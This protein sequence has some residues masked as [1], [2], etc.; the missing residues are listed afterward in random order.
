MLEKKVAKAITNCQIVLEQGI[1]W[2]SVLLIE[3]DK[4]AGYGKMGDTKIPEYAEIIDAEGKYVGPG[5]VDIHVHGGGGVDTYTDP[6]KAENH[7]LRHGE[8]TILATPPYELDRDGFLNAIRTVKEY[9]PKAKTIK[10]FNFEGP[11]T[12]P[13]YGAYSYANPWR[14]PISEEDFKPIVDE[15]GNFAIIWSIAPELEGLIP[16]LEYA[17]KVNPKTIFSVGHSEATPQE[18]RAL[19]KYRPRLTTHTMNAM[20]RK[21]VYG[22][23]RSYGPDEYILKESDVYAEVISDSMAI[24]VR[25]EMQRF[26]LRGKGIDRTILITDSTYYENDPP[27]QFKNIDDLNFDQRGG[28]SGSKMTLEQAC[29]NIMTHTSCGICEAFLM[30]SRNPARLIGLDDEIGT[31]E[32]GKAADL[33]IVDDRFNVKKVILGGEICNF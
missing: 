20:G 3:N 8:T 25:P 13:K 7:F 17:R 2:D 6:E 24:H 27:E 26:I 15:A 21:E 31:I 22:G 19:G 1:L 33:I 5:L 12:N 29:R 9:L 16:F 28:I 4:I 23:T 14:K 32:V 10:G 30:A 11:Y 18:I